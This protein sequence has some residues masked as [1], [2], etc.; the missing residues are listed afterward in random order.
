MNTNYCQESPYMNPENCLGALLNCNVPA[1]M[2][3]ADGTER[4][5]VLARNLGVPFLYGA[6]LDKIARERYSAIEI[7]GVPAS[8]PDS[9]MV[10]LFGKCIFRK[11]FGGGRSYFTIEEFLGSRDCMAGY[12]IENSR[13]A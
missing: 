1:R 9:E 10:R 3:G 5:V 4:R 12:M 13:E 6:P 11:P 2:S 8:V 7:N